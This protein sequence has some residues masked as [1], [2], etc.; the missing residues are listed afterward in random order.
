VDFKATKATFWVVTLCSRV[1][2]FQNSASIFI[3]S[4]C[5]TTQESQPRTPEYE[6]IYICLL[7]QSK[8]KLYTGTEDIVEYRPVARQR[9]R[10]KQLYNSRC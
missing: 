6:R 7:T 4:T 8:S 3:V 5:K 9:Q 10:N 1:G 2:G